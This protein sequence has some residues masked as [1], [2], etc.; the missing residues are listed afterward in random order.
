LKFDEVCDE[1]KREIWWKENFCNLT[2]KDKE[3]VE[4]K[5]G[6]HQTMDD[7]VLSNEQTEQILQFQELTGIDDINVCR[8][9]LIR[10]HWNLEIAFSERERMNEGVLSLVSSYDTRTLAVLNEKFFQQIFISSCNNNSG[11]GPSGGIFGL[12]SYV[13]NSLIHWCNSTLSSFVQTLLSAFAERERSEL[14]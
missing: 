14:I 13:V 10:H 3:K 11:S 8:D 12:F 7:D 5:T 4:Q 6:K 2:R 1:T 9:I